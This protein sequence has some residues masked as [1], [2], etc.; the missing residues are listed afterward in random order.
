MPIVT[1][2]SKNQ[3]TLPAEIVRELGLKAGDKLA[4]ELMNGR[5]VAIREPDS[6]VDY[7]MGAG[8]GVYGGTKEAVDR[9]VAEER[10]AYTTPSAFS[11]HEET[12]HFEDFYIASQGSPVQA[13]LDGLASRR[14]L[15]TATAGEL[16]QDT[17]ASEQRVTQVLGEML[18]P[19]GW[20]RRVAV[21]EGVKYRLRRELAQAIAA[22]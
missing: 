7:V 22:A 11:A 18:V 20:V 17:G 19:R 4:I 8:R 16:A 21:P 6:W 2:S 9:Y 12:E 13:V 3:I 10:A 14:P 1:I 5:I 15:Y